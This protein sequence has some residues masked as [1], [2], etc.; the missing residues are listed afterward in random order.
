MNFFRRL[1]MLVFM[2]LMLATGVSYILISLNVFLPEGCSGTVG[3]IQDSL[4]Y[5][6]AMGFVG[7]LFVLIAVVAPWKQARSMKKNR[8]IAFKNP[9]GEVSVSLSAIE[10]YVR[11]IV[12]DIPGIKDIRSRVD[13]TK[14][15]INIMSDVSMSS[16]ANIPEVTERIQMLVKSSVQGM[17]GVEEKINVKMRVNKITRTAQAEDVPGRR[18]GAGPEEARH[19]PFR[20]M[21]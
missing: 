12:K 14:R 15:G 2:L 1:G 16:D 13:M 10:D 11:K 6:A 5:R 7:G 9:D 3:L 20:E 18:G 19:V 21:E 17:L 8:M 4:Y